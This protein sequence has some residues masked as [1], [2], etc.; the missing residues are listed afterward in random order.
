MGTNY[1]KAG[2][3]QLSE[4]HSNVI[5]QTKHFSLAFK[6]GYF[7][8]LI[9]LTVCFLFLFFFVAT[10]KACPITFLVQDDDVHCW[11]RIR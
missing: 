1:D 4:P 5:G 7:F 10:A 8:R 11:K 9:L 6:G 3:Y 2:D